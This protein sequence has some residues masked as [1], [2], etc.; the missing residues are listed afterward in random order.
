[1]HALTHTPLVH[2]HAPAPA[3]CMPPS[4]STYMLAHPLATHLASVAH[5]SRKHVGLACTCRVS[6][7]R[8]GFVSGRVLG[9]HAQVEGR[10]ARQRNGQGC[11]V[12][13]MYAWVGRWE[14]EEEEKEE[15]DRKMQP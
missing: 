2:P 4:P 6:E 9:M 14:E 10:H 1:M 11:T 3:P 13:V 5:A 15:E 7:H 8:G 12:F